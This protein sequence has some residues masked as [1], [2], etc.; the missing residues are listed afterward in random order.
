MRSRLLSILSLIV[1]SSFFSTSAWAQAAHGVFKVVKGN[2][3][4]TSAGETKK[5]RIGMKVLPKDK[6][7]V[8]KESRAK[9]VMVDKNEINISP[10]SEIEITEYE[11]KPEQGKKDVLINVLYGKMR[12]KVEQKYEDENKFQVKTK[13][14]VAGVRGTDFFTSYNPSTRATRIVTFEGRVQFGIPG[15]GGQILNP[16]MVSVGQTSSNTAGAP[17]APPIEVPKSELAAFDQGT[18]ATSAS[19]SSGDGQERQPPSQGE[20][21][22]EKKEDGPQQ[23][24]AKQDGPKQDGAKE[25]GRRSAGSGPGAP[26]TSGSGPKGP[27]AG[28]QQQGQAGSENRAPASVGPGMGTGMGPGPNAGMPGMGPM[29]RPED[30]ISGPTGNVIQPM[31]PALP[32]LPGFAGGGFIPTPPLMADMP[33]CD[34]CREIIENGTRSLIINVQHNN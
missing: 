34:F 1:V 8:G 32:P 4:V 27:M 18:D 29:L 12:A 21:D 31:M 20:K 26:G 25:D 22:P 9:I 5:A 33:P 3:E 10:D 19:G 30:V 17:P 16:V 14:A 6:I 13:S 23:E 2:V 7:K 24:G 15:P 28:G 11:Y